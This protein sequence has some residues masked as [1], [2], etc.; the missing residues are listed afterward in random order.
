MTFSGTPVAQTV[1]TGTQGYTFAN[2]V[3]DATASGEDI[4]V[5]SVSPLLAASA[6]ADSNTYF[7]YD[8]ATQLNGTAPTIAN[9]NVAFTLDTPLV[10]TKGTLKT[11]A[12]KG[13]IIATAAAANTIRWGIA[14]A[15][16]GAEVT[17]TG[18]STGQAVTPSV[19]AAAGPLMTIA[20]SGQ[21]SVALDSST[22]TGKLIAAN[23]TGNTMTVLKFSATSEQINVTKIRLALTSASSTGIDLANVYIYD[24]STLLG[25]G[26]FGNYAGALGTASTTFTLSTPLQVPANQDKVVT[27]KADIAPIYT[28][29]TVATAG[30][31]V[32]INY[33][34]SVLA[35]ENVGT[36]Q[37][38]GAEIAGYSV[39]TAQSAAYIYK[40]VPTVS[41]KALS[42]NVLAAGSSVPLYRFSV[43]ADAKGEIDLYKFTFQFAT[44][45]ATLASLVLYDVTES[46]EVVVNNENTTVPLANTDYSFVLELN[47]VATTPRTVSAG[48]TRTFELRGQV[49]GTIA[50]GSSVS[51]QLQGDAGL[52]QAN[53]VHTA[54]AAT[55]HGWTTLQNNFV[56]SD[57]SKASHAVGTL[58][59]TNGYLVSGLPSSNLASELV[60]K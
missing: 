6:A 11:V 23:T 26:V 50:A 10:V 7:L 52:S 33:Y 20:A 40:S 36:G 56:W 27:I 5:T 25:S 16:L 46:N 22:P 9:G 31:N 24:G 41:K 38:S 35:T 19:T 59:W 47:D 57:F 21:Y 18:V 1:I 30:H 29:N 45:S 8:G 51:T 4:R 44:S 12:L 42:S 58:D 2:Y 48:T 15:D 32:I 53:G 13:N 34:G 39:T 3:F 54:A 55:V 37:S 28:T 14:S 60:S 43:A 17:A 49:S